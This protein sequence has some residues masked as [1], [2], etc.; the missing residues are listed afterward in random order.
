MTGFALEQWKF[1]YEG[2]D[3]SNSSYFKMLK[4]DIEGIGNMRWAMY[5]HGILM[6]TTDES[7]AIA[8]YIK[9]YFNR[10]WDGFHGYFYTP[11]EKSTGQAAIARSENVYHICFKVFDAYYNAAM[12]SHKEIV[13]Y[14]LESLLPEPSLQCK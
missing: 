11:P 14:C 8:E 3:Q 10:H 5:S 13:K 9:P 2:L 12:I 7:E 4:A 6:S 1:N